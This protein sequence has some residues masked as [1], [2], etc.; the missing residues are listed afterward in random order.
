MKRNS[1]DLLRNEIELS[2]RR[3]ISWLD[4]YGDTSWD[5]DDFYNSRY[6]KWAKSLYYKF[7]IFGK[8]LVSPLVFC[9]ALVPSARALFWPKQRFPLSDA[10]YAMAFGYLFRITG[11]R[12]Y[13]DRAIRYLNSLIETRCAGNDRYCWGYPF[14][15][16]TG[17]G[18]FPAGTPLITTTPYCFEAFSLIHDIDGN[19]RWLDVL[20]SIADH[21]LR[22]Y[23]EAEFEPGVWASSYSPL[24]SR[25]VVNANAYRAF[26][27]FSAGSLL[28]DERYFQAGGR[29][30][31][32]VLH[33]QRPDGS[34]LYAMDGWDDFIDHYHTC[35]V[36]KA[37]CKISRI[38]SRSRCVDAIRNG[39]RYYRENL[40]DGDNLP[41]P[42]A[43]PPRL[44][45]YKRELYDYGECINLCTLLWDDFPELHDILLSVVHDLIERWQLPEG[46][47]KTRQL[48]LGWNKVPMHRWGQS[49]VFRSLC[50]FLMKDIR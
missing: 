16:E 49:I 17:W 35:F 4:S 46:S 18:N 5:V 9:E 13:Y 11:R 48:F 31:D 40:I 7:P 45:I 26:L 36:L 29:Y 34:W 3:Q 42:F 27:L 47:F 32:F 15:W 23:S 33:T 21:A 8:L 39:V 50:S 37:L 22:D 20:R 19:P 25:K 10:H 24:D 43:K 28:S 2:L 30:L 44:I 41:R 12:T 38:E 1:P 6:G 14:D